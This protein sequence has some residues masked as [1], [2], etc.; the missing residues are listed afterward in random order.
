MTKSNKILRAK[1][2]LVFSIIL[3]LIVLYDG[4]NLL[5]NIPKPIDSTIFDALDARID[6]NN[7]NI[8]NFSVNYDEQYYIGLRMMNR[9]K[10]FADSVEKF[11]FYNVGA[12]INEYNLNFNWKLYEDNNLILSGNGINC[13][14]GIHGNVIAFAEFKAQTNKKYKIEFIPGVN[15]RIFE[16]MIPELS[17]SINKASFSVGIE[18]GNAIAEKYRKPI[19][20][21]LIVFSGLFGYFSFLSIKYLRKTK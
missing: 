21:S 10:I 20:I 19:G 9:G 8:R 12:Y 17:I 15:F 14:K 4:I 11:A 13:V 3:T 2:L 1:I 6:V 18:L 16:G 5:V 7:T